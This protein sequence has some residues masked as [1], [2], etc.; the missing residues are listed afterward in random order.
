M[1]ENSP[2][3]VNN[4]P[5]VP[6]D[7]TV[8][9]AAPAGSSA[10]VQPA[11]L[12]PQ[13]YTAVT[14][15][16][17]PPHQGAVSMAQGI[18][19]QPTPLSVVLPSSG[20]DP[21]VQPGPASFPM[22]VSVASLSSLPAVSSAISVS[23][24][25]SLPSATSAP[26]SM[27]RPLQPDMS[28]FNQQ[29]PIVATGPL[30]SLAG[31]AQ[32][33]QGIYAVSSSGSSMAP[34][35]ALSEAAKQQTPLNADGE[36]TTVF[37]PS[38]GSSA[39]RLPDGTVLPAVSVSLT[40]LVPA[41]RPK[42]DANGQPIE[43]DDDTAASA[44]LNMGRKRGANP[45]PNRRKRSW[46]GWCLTCN[47]VKELEERSARDKSYK[48]QLCNACR[49]THLTPRIST[50]FDKGVARWR[51]MFQLQGLAEVA[52]P[53]LVQN[54]L[55]DLKNEYSNTRMTRILH[56]FLNDRKD[57]VP[58]TYA[59]DRSTAELIKVGRQALLKIG[60]PEPNDTIITVDGIRIRG[61]PYR[62]YHADVPMSQYAVFKAAAQQLVVDILNPRIQSICAAPEYA[63]ALTRVGI[64]P[65][66]VKVVTDD[67]EVVAV[68]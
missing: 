68:L 25:S 14:M 6:D 28:G 9:I 36:A 11:Q 46:R 5:A 39:K 47:V 10:V 62:V 50:S 55:R 66:A 26:I 67:T 56:L 22:P 57:T 21:N 2:A 24:L 61:Q 15:P 17:P 7:A 64:I 38:A 42:L 58:I 52:E 30:T 48:F 60:A 19:S 13:A 8:T 16:G 18:T 32:L 65:S 3:V 27:L 4:P 40:S 63:N 12:P 1:A 54:V 41:K 23:S 20:A 37:Y 45:N 33:A 34:L 31:G 29:G 53:I 49:K 43:Y 51:D 35:M 44:I 59:C